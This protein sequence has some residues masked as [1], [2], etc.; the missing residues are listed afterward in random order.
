MPENT[1]S[2]ATQHGFPEL[3]PVRVAGCAPV[4]RARRHGDEG[5]GDEE[6]QLQEADVEAL[7]A[8][9]AKSFFAFC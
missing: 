3:A 1:P 5:G 4:S 2:F 8:A 6:G 7:F 9:R